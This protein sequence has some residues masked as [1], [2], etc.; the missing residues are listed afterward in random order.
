[1]RLFATVFALLVLT[2]FAHAQEGTYAT[3]AS[4]AFAENKPLV[5][6][7]GVKA[8]AIEGAVTTQVQSLE[9]YDRMSVVVSQPGATW[10]EWTATMPADVTDGEIA[11][12]IAPR[13]A[14][15][16]ALAEVNSVREARGL[17][18]YAKDDGLTQAAMSAARFR[19]ERRMT[20]HTP[21][22]FAHIPQGASANAAGC[23]AWSPEMGWG[24]C[25]TY[26]NWRHAGA[27]Y[28]VGEDGRR[29]MHL[30][31]R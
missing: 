20:G 11:K 14:A 1:M 24:S 23:A 26:E 31:V 5:V 29:Y 9:G 18:P 2:S 12:V 22:D 17:P 10:L 6:F 13:G 19:A 16:D 21:N 3:A 30:F 27:A 8:R 25:C 28:V 4:K 7:I 15:V